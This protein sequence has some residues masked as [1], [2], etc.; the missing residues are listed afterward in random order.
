VRLVAAVVV[1]VVQAAGVGHRGEQVGWL[2]AT[3]DVQLC[4]PASA[5]RM[6][7]SGPALILPQAPIGPDHGALTPT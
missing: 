3:D 5:Q 2:Q 4:G 1:V 6:C 7:S